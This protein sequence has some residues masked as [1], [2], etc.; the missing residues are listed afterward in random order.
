MGGC[1]LWR[2]KMIDEGGVGVSILISGGGEGMDALEKTGFV[3]WGGVVYAAGRSDIDVEL[4]P[5]TR[6]LSSVDFILFAP[7]PTSPMIGF[8]LCVL[9][10]RRS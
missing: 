9:C 3:S 8:L 5:F 10:L 6:L 7:V 2:D 1:E 4:E